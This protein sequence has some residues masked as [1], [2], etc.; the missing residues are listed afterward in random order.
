MHVGQVIALVEIVLDALPVEVALQ[1]HPVGAAHVLHAVVV[2]LP[3]NGVEKLGERSAVGIHVVPDEP[4]PGV[5]GNLDQIALAAGVALGEVLLAVDPL[6]D[7]LSIETPAM[8]SALEL[9]T[10]EGS[11]LRLNQLIAAMLAD[12]V[13]RPDPAVIAAHD[14]DGLPADVRREEITRL[15]DLVDQPTDQPDARPHV[16]PLELGEF[17]GSVTIAADRFAPELGL[18]SFSPV[19]S[20]HLPYSAHGIL[21]FWLAA[22]YVRAAYSARLEVAFK[23][24][25]RDGRHS[26]PDFEELLEGFQLVAHRR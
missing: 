11:L 18:R 20:A 21:L 24:G 17:P 12:V 14:Q 26:A 2:E 23:P 7:T 13:E 6:E 25:A 1:G 9:A 16:L 15:G 19:D 4:R 3:G 5:A 10:G 8:V 22:R